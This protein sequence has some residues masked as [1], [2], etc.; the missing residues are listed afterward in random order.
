MVA[1]FLFFIFS[2][3]GFLGILGAI[4]YYLLQWRAKAQI[5]KVKKFEDNEY[6]QFKKKE[7]EIWK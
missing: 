3:T 1:R 5:E 4:T 2:I 6:Q 7:K